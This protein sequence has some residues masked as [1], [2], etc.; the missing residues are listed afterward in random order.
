E[1][2]LVDLEQKENFT[3]E[4]R[5]YED[6]AWYTVM[7]M[8]DDDGTLRVRF[9]KSINEVDQLFEP[10]FFGS[11]EDLQDFEKRFRPLSVQVQDDKC[12]KLVPDV[13]VCAC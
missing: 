13:K 9:E 3:T 7:V 4:F 8:M 6:D 5:S 2:R 1:T 11:M 10:S 12:D